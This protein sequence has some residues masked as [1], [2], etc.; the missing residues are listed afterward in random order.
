MNKKEL[1]YILN[2]PK[3]K[4]EKLYAADYL[5]RKKL[6]IEDSIEYIFSYIS[7]YKKELSKLKTQYGKIKHEIS[8]SNDKLKEIKKTIKETEDYKNQ[9][10]KVINEKIRE[11][12][13]ELNI[14]E[15]KRLKTLEKL[16]PE[17]III[18]DFIL[19]HSYFLPE[20]II[21]ALEECIRAGNTKMRHLAKSAFMVYADESEYEII[22]KMLDQWPFT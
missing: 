13:N 14:D 5:L 8:N 6:E 12:E 17:N 20:N 21:N 10:I 18:S 22:Q 15:K 1:D 4:E 11:K 2:I 9:Q 19:M 16:I 3:T 7:E